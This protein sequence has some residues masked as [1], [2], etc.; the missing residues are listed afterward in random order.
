MS[1][2]ALT[3]VHGVLVPGNEET[4]ER[5][6]KVKNGEVLRGDF[7]KARNG[8]FLRKFFALLDI[9][10]EVWEPA[11]IDTKWG[12]PE[13]NR[14]QFRGQVTVLAGFYDTVFNLDGSVRLT[15]KSISFAKMDEDEF[16]KVY[17]SVA[18]VLLAKVLGNYTRDDLDNRVAQIL[19]FV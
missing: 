3:K 10:Y 12:K 18:N 5:L 1:E 4:C 8:L 15:P 17:S 9:G 11:E 13:K 2:L 14:E 16:G 19:D 7:K 6:E